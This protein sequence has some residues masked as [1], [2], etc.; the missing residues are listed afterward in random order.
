MN[1]WQSGGEANKNKPVVQFLAMVMKLEIITVKCVSFKVKIQRLREN[2]PCSYRKAWQGALLS[3]LPCYKQLLVAGHSRTNINLVC[4]VIFRC[5]GSFKR[6]SDLGTLHAIS[7]SSRLNLITSIGRPSLERV[8]NVC[9]CLLLEQGIVFQ[10][11]GLFAFGT[12]FL[13][14]CSVEF[15]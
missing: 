3:P 9:F 5:S 6:W 14:C 13:R 11:W 7:Q 8:T 15:V 2:S 4:H 12:G 10:R 1:S